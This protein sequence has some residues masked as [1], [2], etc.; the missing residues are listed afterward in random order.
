M[1]IVGLEKI[2]V[3]FDAEEVLIIANMFFIE[4]TIVE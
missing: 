3:D 4:G 1:K 2:I